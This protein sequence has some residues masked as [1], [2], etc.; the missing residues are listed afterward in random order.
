M[1]RIGIMTFL[2]NGN[3]GSS[4][5]AY[6]LQRVIRDMGHDCEHID[7]QPGI[8]E[9]TLNLIR[10]GNSPRL[11]LDGRKKRKV[12]GDQ[13]GMQGKYEAI[14]SF[15][16]RRMHLS[17]VC[18]SRGD[19]RKISGRYDLLLAGSDQIWNPFLTGGVAGAYYCSF[20]KE[21][22]RKFAYAPSFGTDKI[23]PRHKKKME[24]YIK[25][26]S[27]ISV[28][29]KD[30]IQYMKEHIG[31]EAVQLIDPVFLVSAAE[32]K[33]EAVKIDGI[34]EKY[35][36][37][38][39][40]QRD[41]TVYSYAKKLKEQ[42][43]LPIIEIS[44]YGYQPSFVDI[45]LINIGP[46][47]FLGLFLHATYVVSNSYHGLIFSI[48]FDKKLCLVP[49]KRFR[50]RINNL[51]ALLDRKEH[52]LDEDDLLISFS[53]PTL[54]GCILKE[55]EKSIHYLQENIWS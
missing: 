51:L 19:L 21:R 40:M 34:P 12:R 26:L 6:A 15:Y 2:H 37:L 44:R 16:G 45:S 30:S 22:N 25:E 47:E 55:R 7:Y 29:E 38:Y 18:R 35:I 46:Q 31:R 32:W 17:P 9:K 20:V 41:E 49:S 4:L 36:L 8:P 27:A 24:S 28:R 1:S 50:S 39:I 14:R 3:Y 52:T 48:V 53:D 54:R 42:F 10:C 5:Q 43:H 13:A 11:L 33:K 23:S